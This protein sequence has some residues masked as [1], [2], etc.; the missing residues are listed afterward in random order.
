MFRSTFGS[1]VFKRALSRPASTAAASKQP[2]LVGAAYH[3]ML[4]RGRQVK[5]LIIFT[6]N[7]Q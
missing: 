2:N 4:H 1:A 5:Q 7:I 3:E 6:S